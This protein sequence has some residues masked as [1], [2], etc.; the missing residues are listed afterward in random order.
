MTPSQQL[1]LYR[2]QESLGAQR[3]LDTAIALLH[4][5]RHDAQGPENERAT[6][7]MVRLYRPQPTVAF[8]Q[9]DQRLPGFA[10]AVAAARHR[11]FTPLVRRAGGRA[12]AYHRGSL[13][14]DHIEPD[15]DPI[16]ESRARFVAFGELF[17]DVLR[18]CGLDAHLG[19]IPHEYCY[20]EHSVHGVKRD[21]QDVR[22]KLV[23]TAQRQIAAGWLFSSSIIVEQGSIIR[24]VLSE[25]YAA[26]G[27]PWD[28]LT[29]GAASD[30]QPG[31]T[32]DGVEEALLQTYAQYWELTEGVPQAVVNA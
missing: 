3:D 6:P 27:I 2:Q 28:P 7:P 17:V 20:G 31:I 12:A 26:M 1:L 5:T 13:V 21:E 22:I 14:V 10:A 18:R 11:G 25:V 19:P 15:P 16:R 29:A 24:R 32:V 4:G 9:R 23:G 30:V 8:G